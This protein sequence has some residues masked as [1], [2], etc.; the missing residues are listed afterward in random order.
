M[1]NSFGVI[2]YLCLA[3]SILLSNKSSFK[4]V[5]SLLGSIFIFVFLKSNEYQF[6]QYYLMV[7]SLLHFVALVYVKVSQTGKIR[8]T[9]SQR[10][11]Y[12]NNLMPI[13]SIILVSIFTL[14]I[15]G[16]VDDEMLKQK[17]KL[18]ANSSVNFLNYPDIQFV[19]VSTIFVLVIYCAKRLR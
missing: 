1:N 7:V 10:N 8:V 19:L 17:I 4:I 15:V 11:K 12:S 14:I 2:L 5:F 13:I 9:P 6:T 16:G 3:I 18:T